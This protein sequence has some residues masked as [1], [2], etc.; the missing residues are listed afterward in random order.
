MRGALVSERI[1]RSGLPREIRPRVDRLPSVRSFLAH[2]ISHVV[3]MAP[4]EEMIWANACRDVA[5]VADFDVIRDRTEMQDPREAMC[6]NRR[7]AKSATNRDPAVSV[8]G[9]GAGPDPTGFRLRDFFPE[10]FDQR[11]RLRLGATGMRAVTHRTLEVRIREGAAAGPANKGVRCLSHG[12]VI[13][14]SG[15]ACQCPKGA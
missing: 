7:T 6:A 11:S 1:R 15:I 2:R 9:L 4:E 8:E 12:Q 13:G 10:A 3:L 14:Y 5:A